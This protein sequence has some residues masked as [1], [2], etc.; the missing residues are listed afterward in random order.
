LTGST[1]IDI[2]IQ[3]KLTDTNVMIMIGAA[4]VLDQLGTH[5]NVF[6]PV[7]IESLRDPDFSALDEK[8]SILLK[9]KGEATTAVPILINI[10]TNAAELGNPTNDFVRQEVTSALRQIQPS[11]VPQPAHQAE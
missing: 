7:V 5:P 8:L 4:E 9:H 6:M 10:L 11:D 2:E 1:K 3:Q